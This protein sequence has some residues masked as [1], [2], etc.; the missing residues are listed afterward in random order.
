MRS[1]ETTYI[2]DGTLEQ[3][4]IDELVK[5]VTELIAKSGGKVIEEKQWG[6][7]RLAY[8]INKRQY[9]YYVILNHE[10]PPAVIADIEKFF[11]LNQNILRFLTILL[12]PQV[13][14]LIATDEERKRKEEEKALELTK[15][16]N[17]S[18]E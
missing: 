6:K 4:N 9:G 17:K 1:Y 13:L 8:E 10:S 2:I 5:R 7:R 15:S 11:K 18:E 14:K 12:T 16:M 3:N